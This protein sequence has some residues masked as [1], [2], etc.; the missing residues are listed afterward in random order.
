MDRNETLQVCHSFLTSFGL[1]Y[2][3]KTQRKPSQRGPVL[4]SSESAAH[5]A[6]T[7]QKLW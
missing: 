1:T 6:V 4:N 3:T 2:G 5:R 7:L